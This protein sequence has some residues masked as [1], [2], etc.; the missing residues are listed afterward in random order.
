ML[1][2]HYDLRTGFAMDTELVSKLHLA[3]LYSMIVIGALHSL[4][5]Q[6]DMYNRAWHIETYFRCGFPFDDV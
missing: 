1:D 4:M 6:F 3:I 2:L 5:F